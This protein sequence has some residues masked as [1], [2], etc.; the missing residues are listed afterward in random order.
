MK[1]NSLSGDVRAKKHLGQHF[2]KDEYIA[3]QIVGLLAIGKDAPYDQVL[4]VGPGMGV[5]TKYLIPKIATNVVE[6]DVES[7]AYLQ[8]HFPDLQERIWHKDFL[9]ADWPS[10]LG[11]QAFA[12]IGNFPY[13]ISSPIFFRVLELRDQI[14]EVVGMLQKEVAERIAAPAGSRASGI[15]SVF[16]QTFYEVSYC[17]TVPPEVFDPPP[18]VQSG[19]VRLLRNE[20]KVLPCS[21]KMFRRVVKQ[22][23][24]TRRKTLRN[25][26]KSWQLSE[27]LTSQ[28]IF[29]K[30]AEQLNVEDF[31]YLT[32][33]IETSLQQP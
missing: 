7:V 29:D 10:L 4:E 16:L 9:T 19:V 24:H 3:E 2:L 11:D 31:L 13:N 15:L 5:L 17:F 27:N 14:P 30:R 8:R 6:I 32:Q 20:R 26:L 28:A 33:Q 23:F 25:A 1:K 18:K 12:L 22:A 21:E